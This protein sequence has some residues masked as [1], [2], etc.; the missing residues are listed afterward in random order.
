M[1]EPLESVESAAKLLSLS[2]WTIRAYIRQGRIKPV[3]VGR[4]V[5]MSH[6]ELRRIVAE[7]VGRSAKVETG[8]VNDAKD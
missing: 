2:P 7:G 8:E 3:R 4:R 6:A 1:F 5:L